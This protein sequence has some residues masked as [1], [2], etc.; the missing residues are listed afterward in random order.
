MQTSSLAKLKIAINILRF[1]KFILTSF[2]Q[3]SW[4]FNFLLYYLSQ[5]KMARAVF[6]TV[7]LHGATLINRIKH[8]IQSYVGLVQTTLVG[9]AT[10]LGVFGC[11]AA[12]VIID[13]MFCRTCFLKNSLTVVENF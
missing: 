8:I 4:L 7:Y 10:G 11:V 1:Q 3:N 2:L 6:P 9:E 12:L 5:A 13:P